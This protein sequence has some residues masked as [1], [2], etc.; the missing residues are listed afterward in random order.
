VILPAKIFEVGEQ[1]VTQQM[2]FVAD[3]IHERDVGD[4]D[5]KQD[6]KRPEVKSVHNVRFYFDSGVNAI[7]YAL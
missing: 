5:I 2:L 4:R 6:D 7:R 3:E 1:F